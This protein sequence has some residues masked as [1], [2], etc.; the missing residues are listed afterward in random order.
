MELEESGQMLTA[1][2]ST[3]TKG[4]LLWPKVHLLQ[5]LYLTVAHSTPQEHKKGRHLYSV[6]I[7]LNLTTRDRLPLRQE[8]QYAH[9]GS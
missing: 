3:M 5:L 6:A 1:W 7:P 8:V 4:P 2:P 9:H